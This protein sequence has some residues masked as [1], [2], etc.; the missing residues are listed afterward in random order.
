M[1]EKAY[2]HDLLEA[3]ETSKDQNRETGFTWHS[4]VQS[5]GVCKTQERAAGE[6]PIALSSRNPSITT[7][8]RASDFFTFQIII[9]KSLH[10]PNGIAVY[11]NDTYG[12]VEGQ[13]S[14]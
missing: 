11:Q 1:D 12:G 10:G 14:N 3:V 6:H 13:L 4:E 8:L 2:P 5:V 7:P 9:D